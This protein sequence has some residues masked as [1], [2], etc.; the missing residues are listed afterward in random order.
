M[1]FRSSALAATAAL[2]S[3]FAWSQT[4][5]V[6]SYKIVKTYPHDTGA[7]TE[8]L[9]FHDGALWESTGENGKSSIRRIDLATG[10]ALEDHPLSAL[11][12]GEGITFFGA[13][14]YQLTYKNGVAFAYDPKT[15]RQIESYSY[16]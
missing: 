10:K 6:H 9:E 4:A 5:P 13:R 15:F 16:S 3:A 7:W 12:Y 11:Y 2:L 14:V 1:I 8:G